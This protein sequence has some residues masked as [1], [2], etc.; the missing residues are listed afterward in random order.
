MLKLF[1]EWAQ[2]EKTAQGQMK[3]LIFRS[4]LCFK[5]LNVKITPIQ[6]NINATAREQM[7]NIN[8]KK[9]AL[10]VLKAFWTSIQFYKK[11]IPL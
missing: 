4:S 1:S 11:K 5:L 2:G 10:P 3:G 9:H 7:Q 6:E 8:F